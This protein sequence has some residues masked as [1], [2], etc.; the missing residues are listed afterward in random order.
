MNLESP[1]RRAW[2]WPSALLWRWP[3]IRRRSIGDWRGVL[4]IEGMKLTLV[5]HVGADQATADSPDQAR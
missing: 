3:P 1:R 2:R 5:F 4:E